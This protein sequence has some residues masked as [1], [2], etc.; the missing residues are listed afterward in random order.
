VR[1]VNNGPSDAQ[2]VVVV[3]RLPLTSKKIVYVTDSG[4][5]ACAYDKSAHT[6]ICDYGTLA[7]GASVS[8][9]IVVDVRGSVRWIVNIAEVTTSTTDPNGGNNTAVKEVYVKGGPEKEWPKKK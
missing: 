6:V 1:V 7:A 8:V 3:D 9:N 4:N 5:G 2:D